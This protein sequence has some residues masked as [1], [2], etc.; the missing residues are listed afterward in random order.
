MII[1]SE[2]KSAAEPDPAL[3]GKSF[4]AAIS[5]RD[6]MLVILASILSI[7]PENSDK[8]NSDKEESGIAAVLLGGR[9]IGTGVND[10][11]GKGCMGSICGTGV[12]I[13]GG[14]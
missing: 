12:S 11:N 7:L 8:E 4:T 9:S 5:N 6:S 3:A 1:L 2:N 13:E 14:A 10:G